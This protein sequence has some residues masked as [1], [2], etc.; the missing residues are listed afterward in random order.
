MIVTSE[1]EYSTDGVVCRAF[2]AYDDSLKDHR[3]AV[4]IA[5]DWEGRGAFPCQKARLLAEMGYVGFALDLY[6]QAQLGKDKEQRRAFMSPLVENRQRLLTRMKA[7]FDTACQLPQVNPEQIT[8]IGYCFGGLCVLDLARSNA[9]VKAVVSFHGILASPPGVANTP[10]TA[11]VMA[12]HGYDDPLV[13]P[14]QVEAFATEMTERKADWQAHLYGLTYHSFTN[15]QA[16]DDEM[17]LHYNKQADL[18]SWSSMQHFLKESIG[19]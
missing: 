12:L 5:H 3:P 14:T 4:L 10:I 8:A 19:Q 16:N 7:G 9:N 15:P 2:V 17:G 18:R 1:I 13:Q 6:G 11:K